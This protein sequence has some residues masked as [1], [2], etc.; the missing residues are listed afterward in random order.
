LLSCALEHAN[1]NSFAVILCGSTDRA[2]GPNEIANIGT[3]KAKAA[4]RIILALNR[5]IRGLSAFLRLRRD[6]LR[7]DTL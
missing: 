5:A 6:T 7:R 4:L 1:N 3:N 2:D